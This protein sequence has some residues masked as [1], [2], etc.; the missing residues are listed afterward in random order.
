M[1]E[2]KGLEKRSIKKAFHFAMKGFGGK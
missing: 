2:Y 1:I